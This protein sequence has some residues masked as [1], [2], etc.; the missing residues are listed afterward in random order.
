MSYHWILLCFA[1]FSDSRLQCFH[2][3]RTNRVQPVLFPSS[4][5]SIST[6]AYFRSER[7]FKSKN[8]PS[9]HTHTCTALLLFF[10]TA[11]MYQWLLC[12]SSDTTRLIV[13]LIQT[14]A[15]GL[16]TA[17]SLARRLVRQ[18]LTAWSPRATCFEIKLTF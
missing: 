4:C 1:L 9:P 18:C 2:S 13:N 15:Y 6:A 11:V 7:E 8:P 12:C 10:S 17:G 16:P 3:T 14:P 5:C